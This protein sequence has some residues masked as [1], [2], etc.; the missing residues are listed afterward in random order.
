MYTRLQRGIARVQ[1]AKKGVLAALLVCVMS[2]QTIL[3][4]P[5]VLVPAYGYTAVK[6]TVTARSGFVRKEASTS[7]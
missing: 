7:S 2:F 1:V 3:P 5:G 4:I 6:G